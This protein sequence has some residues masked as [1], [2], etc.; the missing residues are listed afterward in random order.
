MNSQP[1]G[2][3]RWRLMRGHP[4]AAALVLL[5]ALA[6]RAEAGRG[7]S[8]ARRQPARG[9]VAR[10]AHPARRR[11]ALHAPGRRERGRPFRR[12][13]ERRGEGADSTR[14]AWRRA[15]SSCAST[16]TTRRSAAD[17]G[18]RSAAHGG[19]VEGRPHPAALR[20]HPGRPAPLPPGAEPGKTEGPAA[21]GRLGGRLQEEERRRARAGRVPPG[22]RA[23]AGNLPDPHRRPPLPRGRLP[24]RRAAAF[25]LRR[26]PRLPLLGAGSRRTARSRE[27]SGRE[28]GRGHSLDRSPRARLRARTGF[29]T[30]SPRP[31]SP[32]PRGSCASP[33][34][35]S[36]AGPC[37]SATSASGG[38]S[39]S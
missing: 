16:S 10:G 12:G 33:S 28:L 22:G 14:S 25:H 6:A 2:E 26:R 38:R 39:W 15:A 4:A 32:T 23:G 7:G 36:R 31:A 34:P 3:V 35:T 9:N 29:P 21:R 27:S 30:R 8:S 18:G 13:P 37:R 1:S 20:R 24:R 17:L 5:A 19:M 11:A